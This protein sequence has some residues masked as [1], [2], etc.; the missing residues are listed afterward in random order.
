FGTV[1]TPENGVGKDA[2]NAEQ[3]TNNEYGFQ[4]IDDKL[5]ESTDDG[6]DDTNDEDYD[7]DKLMAKFLG[8]ELSQDYHLTKKFMSD[9]SNL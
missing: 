7:K 5:S 3:E 1:N 2:V 6:E 4:D 9:D 8:A